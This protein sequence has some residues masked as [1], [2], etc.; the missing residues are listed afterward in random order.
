MTSVTCFGGAQYEGGVPPHQGEIPKWPLILRRRSGAL[1]A[2]PEGGIGW[3]HLPVG[4]AHAGH[5]TNSKFP[6]LQCCVLAVICIVGDTA[7]GGKREA[8]YAAIATMSSGVR[9]AMTS[10][11]SCAEAPFRVPCCMS[12]I[13]RTM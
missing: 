4:A 3:T 12:H 8:T 7:V 11:I 5:M 2:P 13:C 1:F 9:L 6:I 10:F